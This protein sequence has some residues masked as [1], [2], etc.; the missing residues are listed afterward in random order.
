MRPVSG[1]HTSARL[2]TLP[3][4]WEEAPDRTDPAEPFCPLRIIIL[5]SHVATVHFPATL[6]RLNI[7][8][9]SMFDLRI[10]FIL[11]TYSLMCPTGSKVG[12]QKLITLIG[13]ASQGK[14]AKHQKIFSEFI[15]TFH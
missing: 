2:A 12:S 1:I 11:R 7:I 10:F 15:I 14:L 8:T 5:H 9:N 13:A 6:C 3:I 4:A